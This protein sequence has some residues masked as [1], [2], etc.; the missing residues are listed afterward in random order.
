M[1]LGPGSPIGRS[2]E[3]FGAL[4]IWTACGQW[5]HPPCVLQALDTDHSGSLTVGELYA[6]GKS[7]QRIAL[8]RP[9]LQRSMLEYK[10][11][12]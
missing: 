5:L 6:A 10:L 9:E 2:H 4:C 7:L 1:L 11:S 12:R 3:P 8:E